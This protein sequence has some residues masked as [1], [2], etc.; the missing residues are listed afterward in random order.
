M[1]GKISAFGIILILIFLVTTGCMEI[2]QYGNTVT[3]ESHPTSLLYKISYGYWINCSGSGD[4]EIRYDCDEPEVHSGTV[5]STIIHDSSY[6]IKTLATYNRIYS[7]LIE[8][9]INRDYNLGL[10]AE[11]SSN[12]FMVPDLSGEEALDISEIE[13]ENPGIIAQYTKAQ[14]NDTIIF[15]DPNN[16]DIKDVANNVIEQTQSD[17]SLII[18]KELFK[19]LKQNTR[20]KVHTRS[21]YVQPCSDT[22]DSETG[23]CDDLSFLYISLCRSAG[24]PARFIRGFLVE[25][26]Q[27]VAHAWAEVF[28]GEEVGKNGWIPV[29]CAGTSNNIK[30][31]V[32]QNFGIESAGHLRL[33]MDDGSNESLKISLSG[34]S[35]VTYGNRIIVPEDFVDVDSYSIAKSSKLVV[36]ENGNRSYN[37]D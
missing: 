10:T 7:W 26:Y 17:N 22:I 30:T 6:V 31:E 15:I 21:N 32:N 35:F 34:L 28:V 33:F 9:D 29:E 12:S 11:V 2:T 20:Y 14:S 37:Q 24:I 25:Q 1:K 13:I 36:D 8:S 3:Y 16:Q 19:W 4:Y 18:A 27:A 5:L 23:D